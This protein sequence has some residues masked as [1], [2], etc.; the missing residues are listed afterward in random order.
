[1]TELKDYAY[2]DSAR[3]DSYVEQI[4][5]PVTYD[6][7]P[8]WQAS[9][10]LTGP[11][12]SGTQE[13]AARQRTASEKITILT[14]YLEKKGV[15]FSRRQLEGDD[16]LRRDHMF[17]REASLARKI[18]IPPKKEYETTHGGVTLWYSEMWYP[19]PF[20]RRDGRPQ[21]LFLIQDFRRSDEVLERLSSYSTL[22]SLAELIA[23]DLEKT[24]GA[25]IVEDWESGRDRWQKSVDA[26]PE[27]L[28]W[29]EAAKDYSDYETEFGR[30]LSADPLTVLQSLGAV[31]GA[32]QIIES[33]YRVRQVFEDRRSGSARFVTVGYPLYIAT[34]GSPAIADRVP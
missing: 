16:Y 8:K 13:R 18:L 20:E 9:M 22:L 25:R 19:D 4:A 34:Q 24:L 12:V 3:L 15:L 14:E 33:L 30:R 21:R 31:T 23:D 17:V 10:G 11:A 27:H 26:A 29:Q 5:G 32:P 1:M 7:I 28:K 2:L 6:K